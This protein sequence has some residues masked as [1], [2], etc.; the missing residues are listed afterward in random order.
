MTSLRCRPLQ[1]VRQ[2]SLR[3]PPLS[4]ATLHADAVPCP[5]LD[6]DKSFEKV[7]AP[8]CCCSDAC[9]H[10]GLHCCTRAALPRMTPLLWHPAGRTSLL[11]HHETL[12]APAV[13][14]AAVM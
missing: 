5:L 7:S 4:I 12:H 8:L 6:L 9:R 11:R 10:A 1:R 2:R 14:N 13:F 3:W